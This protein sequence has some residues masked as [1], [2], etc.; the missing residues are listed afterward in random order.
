MA[1]E[2][3]TQ[4]GYIAVTDAQ[5]Q[6]AGLVVWWRLSGGLNL[7]ELRDAWER[8]GLDEKLTP[9]EPTMA[10]AL[11]RAVSELRAPDRIVRSLPKGGFGVV[12]E[13]ANTASNENDYRCILKASL[14]PLGRL[15]LE[16]TEDILFPKVRASFEQ[17]Q[18]ELTQEDVSPWLTSIMK[19]IA[20][21]PLRD[22][23][24]I[25]FVPRFAVPE[26]EAI[27]GAVRSSSKHSLFGMPAMRTA[28]AVS[29]IE[30]AI[31]QEAE[32][33][34][35]AVERDLAEYDLG[36]RA[37]QNRVAMTNAIE[38]KLVKYEEL[39]GGRLE[40]LHE[41]LDGLRAAVTHAIVVAQSKAD[42]AE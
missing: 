39:L 23:G 22:T 41:R 14:D 28:E 12:R 29:A 38:S 10:T 24:G 21:V 5:L 30:D 37:L 35:A 27:A 7:P 25:Y 17:Y 2:N 4:S 34:A 9:S 36:E 13:T 20:A 26:W 8:A 42:A 18:A 15:E 16:G 11:R 31:A 1:K 6:T 3:V 40:K 32:S 33:A 19:K